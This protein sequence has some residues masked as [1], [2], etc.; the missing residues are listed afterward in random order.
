M[1]FFKYAYG[2]FPIAFSNVPSAICHSFLLVPLYYTFPVPILFPFS[3][4][5][6]TCVLLLPSLDRAPSSLTT[7][8]PPRGPFLLSW[9]L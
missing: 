2:C 7:S 8:L 3:R 9:L 6:S 1:C 5:H 4:P